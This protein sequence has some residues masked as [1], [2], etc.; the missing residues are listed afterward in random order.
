VTVHIATAVRTSRA[1]AIRDAI[2]AGSGPGK[3]RIYSGAQPATANTAASGT[4]LLE[5]VLEDPCGTV[6]DGVLTFDITPAID[7]D[8]DALSTATAG[9]GRFLDSD[10]DPVLDGA[11]GA[12][13]A[14]SDTTLSTGQTVA[15]VSVTLSEA[16]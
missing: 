9:W 15:L 13:I 7:I 6:T 2:D 14:L 1:T 8:D 11:V 3:L 10:D 16:V 4:L 5:L 12:E